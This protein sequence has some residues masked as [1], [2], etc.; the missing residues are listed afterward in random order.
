MS[1]STGASSIIRQLRYSFLG[2]GLS[3]G[4]VFP[5]YANFFVNWKEGMLLWF[6]IGCIIAGVSI[7]V[8]NGK[9]LEWL[10]LSKLKLVAV[11]AARIRKGDLREGCG[12]RSN[13]C[14]GEITEGFDS[15][16]IGLRETLSEMTISAD[17][18]D[19]SAR[20]LGTSCTHSPPRWMS[21]AKTN[22]KLSK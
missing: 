22:M 11:A 13:D 6:V 10:M 9:L 7:G 5:F 15:M 1:T 17:R 18:V 12:V 21:I 8:V 4:L 20:E 3:M 19:V 14:I 2:F 16:A